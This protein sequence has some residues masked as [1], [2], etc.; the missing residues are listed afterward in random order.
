MNRIFLLLAGLIVSFACLA[1]VDLNTATQAQ[2]ETLNGVGPAKARAI[3]DWRTRNGAFR[4]V[5]EL[6]QV[7]GFGHAMVERIR[8]SL[9]VSGSRAPV[10]RPTPADKALRK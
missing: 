1:A 3:I 8:P 9:S 10:A 5:D 2:L 6:D 4:T 7:P